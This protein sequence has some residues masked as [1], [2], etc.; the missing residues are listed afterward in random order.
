MSDKIAHSCMPFLLPSCAYRKIQFTRSCVVLETIAFYSE[1]I[2]LTE[3][4]KK[5]SKENI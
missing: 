5:N 2:I 4:I 3:S 1:G